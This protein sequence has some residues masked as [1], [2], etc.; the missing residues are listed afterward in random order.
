MHTA[1]DA[2]MMKT[3]YDYG[4][5]PRLLL[6]E[7]ATLQSD[8][9]EGFARGDIP[10]TSQTLEGREEKEH[11]MMA[12][13]ETLNER[14][15]LS[16]EEKTQRLQQIEAHLEDPGLLKNFQ[17]FDVANSQFMLP[18]YFA[19][20]DRRIA[21]VM[22][23]LHN[24]GRDLMGVSRQV[25]MS[26]VWRQMSYYEG[27]NINERRKAKSIVQLIREKHITNAVSF[28]GGN[29]PERH[30]GL[31][32]DL[33][34]TVFD[35]GPHSP[36]KELF[37]DK[38]LTR[39]NYVQESL[40]RAPEHQHLIKA[41]GLVWMHGVSMY[42]DEAE[43]HEMTGAILC[44]AALLHPGG[45]MAYDYLVWTESMRRVISTQNW[46]YN[47]LRPMKIY[48]GADEAIS[49][50]RV[51]VDA[52]NEQLPS[53]TSMVVDDISANLV[54]PWGVTSVQLRLQKR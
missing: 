30:Y 29:I 52:V 28:G 26:D 16:A 13:R 47:P 1:W 43:K 3:A 24:F 21:E 33:K 4:V 38:E 22:D 31:P 12:I 36:L 20:W 6:D 48:T 42:L 9:S 49:E 23:Y 14:S 8:L 11:V 37:T 7:W 19:V 5:L 41:H 53:G 18:F 39:I 32:D 17:F 44:G 50:G 35:D 2:P 54:E 40:R 51:T 27:M 10:S 15:T 46:P 45:Y 34:L 25:P